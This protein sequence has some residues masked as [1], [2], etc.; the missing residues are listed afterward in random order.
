[1]QLV[2]AVRTALS[3]YTDFTGRANRPEYWWFF[4]AAF[5]AS[6]VVSAVSDTLG[7]VLSLAI[8]VPGLAAGVRRLHDTGRSGWW[9]LIVFIPIV[10]GILLIVWLASE[11]QPGENAYG[12]P[13]TWTG[14]ATPPPPPAV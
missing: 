13:S 2:E 12:A 10:G 9:Y 11:G 4:L 14:A 6:L 5:L 8:I 7:F 3:K 1:M